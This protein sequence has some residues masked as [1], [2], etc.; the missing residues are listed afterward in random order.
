MQNYVRLL[1][2][3][4]F[5]KS[6]RN[7]RPDVVGAEPAD[8]T[9][10]VGVGP[11]LT[12]ALDV[13]AFTH[14]LDLSAGG[15]NLQ[16]GQ[17][18]TPDLLVNGKSNG[19]VASAQQAVGQ[20]KIISPPV[21]Q[22]KQEPPK[23]Y[24]AVRQ[25]VQEPLS[26][27][28]KAQIPLPP[29]QQ[30]QTQK[31]QLSSAQRQ[32]GLNSL[33][34][35]PKGPCP[36]DQSPKQ[37][38]LSGFTLKGPIPQPQT[39]PTLTVADASGASRQAGKCE[40]LTS[41]DHTKVTYEPHSVLTGPPAGGAEVYRDY[42]YELITLSDNGGSP[43]DLA[44]LAA[45]ASDLIDV[46][47]VDA[48]EMNR[49]RSSRATVAGAMSGLFGVAAAPVGDAWRRD[50]RDHSDSEPMSGEYDIC[51]LC[52]DTVLLG[53][54]SRARRARTASRRA[55][56]PPPHLYVPARSMY[57]AASESSAVDSDAPHDIGYVT[58]DKMSH[59]PGR[60]FSS[61]VEIVA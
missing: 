55:P 9:G 11:A 47:V 50:R 40:F 2:F 19:S 43:D 17:K 3:P 15:V 56:P 21:Q 60:R 28:Q 53:R 6:R 45:G 4:S 8:V 54:A 34:K 44:R 24:L 32:N 1:L 49:A 38:T 20:A 41:L 51:N 7:A 12:S 52:S 5:L 25:T 46:P 27:E 29:G 48:A 59:G 39:D 23:S 35:S 58:G 22:A 30:G 42:L 26:K 13:M 14:D 33:D 31:E 10:G 16:S 37:P 36:S 57:L 61:R 18:H